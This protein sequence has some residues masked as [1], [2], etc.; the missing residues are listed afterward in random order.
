MSYVKFHTELR[1]DYLIEHLSNIKKLKSLIKSDDI[2]LLSLDEVI[3]FFD[4][5]LSEHEENKRL[6]EVG[7][8]I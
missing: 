6:Q 3:N 7:L 8:W 1:E 4:N 5:V 2:L